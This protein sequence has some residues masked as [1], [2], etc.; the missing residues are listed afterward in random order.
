MFRALLLFRYCFLEKN[1]I[2]RSR[3]M[4]STSRRVQKCKQFISHQDKIG[5]GNGRGL[6]AGKVLTTSF[7]S[8]SVEDDFEY[9]SA[10]RLLPLHPRIMQFKI[11]IYYPERLH[12]LSCNQQLKMDSTSSMAVTNL[13]I[14][15]AI[16]LLCSI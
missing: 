16:L 10:N 11:I 12:F 15:N 2:N 5:N 6:M 1:K 7:E 13:S 14:S 4:Y 3:I 8:I 9:L